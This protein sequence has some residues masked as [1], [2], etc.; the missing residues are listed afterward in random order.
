MNKVDLWVLVENQEFYGYLE[1]DHE[2]SIQEVGVGVWEKYNNF[3]AYYA[4]WENGATSQADIY[5]IEENPDY[6]SDFKAK[7]DNFLG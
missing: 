1:F 2:P 4:Q 6:G 7:L 3:T 5:F